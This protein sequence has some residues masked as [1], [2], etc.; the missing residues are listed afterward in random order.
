MIGPLVKVLL[1][2]GAIIVGYS[3]F[4]PKK[5]YAGETGATSPGVKLKKG[6]QAVITGKLTLQ[7]KDLSAK[8]WQETAAD[9]GQ[10]ATLSAALFPHTGTV[11]VDSFTPAPVPGVFTAVV[12]ARR[13]TTYIPSTNTVGPYT[14]TTVAA[15]PA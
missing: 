1:S 11:T 13:A 15:R 12:T 3:I 7:G 2:A 5:A 14:V 6:Q 10:L 9:M 4:K 8:I